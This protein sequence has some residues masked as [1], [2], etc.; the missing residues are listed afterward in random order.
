VAEGF[1]V[2]MNCGNSQ[3]A[4]EPSWS[5]IPLAMMRG[6]RLIKTLGNLQDLRL[7]IYRRRGRRKWLDGVEQMLVKK[8]DRRY[9]N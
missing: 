2:A 1:A 7:R 5:V 4:K 9:A 3:G 6:G 8:Q